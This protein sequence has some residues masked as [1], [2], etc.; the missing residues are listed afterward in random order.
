MFKEEYKDLST[1]ELVGIVNI[2][3]EDYTE[4]AIETAKTEL[5]QRGFSHLLVPYIDETMLLEN[6]EHPIF[7]DL[8]K[9]TTFNRMKDLIDVEFNVSFDE[10]EAVE[11]LYKKLLFNEDMVKSDITLSLVRIIH[12]NNPLRKDIQILGIEDGEEEKFQLGLYRD[13]EWLGFKINVEEVMNVGIERYLLY[14]MFELIKG[15]AHESE[16]IVSSDLE[17]HIELPEDDEETEDPADDDKGFSFAKLF[18]F[19]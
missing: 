10:V 1:E 2:E 18:G 19:K 6:V 3:N 17:M 13:Y 16:E 12:V 5:L 11:A 4:E 15:E 8:V 14:C 7:Y 9:R